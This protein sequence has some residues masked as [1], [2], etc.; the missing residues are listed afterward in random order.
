LNP[1][2]PRPLFKIPG[3]RVAP[4]Y[5]SRYDVDTSGQ[6]FLVLRPIDDPQTLP[7]TE[8]VNWSPRS[9]RN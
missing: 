4:P 7:L 1:E 2:K 6:R 8:L 5:A 3:V 9:S